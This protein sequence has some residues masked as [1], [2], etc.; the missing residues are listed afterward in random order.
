MAVLNIEPHLTVHCFSPA[1]RMAAAFVYPA[2]EI[3]GR[4]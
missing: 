4:D 2:G 1:L 3:I